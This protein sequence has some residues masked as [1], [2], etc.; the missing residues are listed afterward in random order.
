MKGYKYSEACDHIYVNHSNSM[1]KEQNATRE[2]VDKIPLLLKNELRQPIIEKILN[3]MINI[4]N[5]LKEQHGNIDEVRVELAREL[6]QSKDERAQ[7]T[8]R[9][10][11]N[12]RE[13]KAIEERIREHGG[14]T[15]QCA[16]VPA[17][18]RRKKM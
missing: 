9:I 17:G 18:L 16:S 14:H 3:Q 13:N 6:K 11:K 5:A 12:E 8:E 15:A 4:V 2:L 10:N 1:T 7:T